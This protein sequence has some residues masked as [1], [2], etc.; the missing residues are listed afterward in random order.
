MVR[1]CWCSIALRFNG[2]SGGQVGDTGVIR[3]DRF[4]FRVTD[5]KKENDFMLH[6]GEV[7]DGRVTV[8]EPATAEVDAKRRNAI[9]RAHTATHLLHHAL[10]NILGKHAQQ[11]GSKVEPDRLRFDFANPEAV[12]RERLR[13]IEEAVNAMILEAAPVSWSHM[14]IAEAR[15]QGAMALFGEKYPDIV[16]V[17]RMGDYSRELCGGTHLDSV[18]QVG[19]FKIIGE[20]SVASGIRRITAL[21]G[22]GASAHV[23]QEE[24]LLLGLAA[25]LRVP[26]TQIADRV[27]GLV[28]EVKTLKKQ[29]TQRKTEVA[30]KT[31]A[32]DL[33]RGAFEL[34]GASVIIHGLEG[35][36]LDE[37]R[38]LID[39]LRRKKE[40]GLAVLLAAAD[41]GKV[42]LVAGVTRDL[43]E[44]GLHAGNWLKE[45]A[46]V[47]GGGGGGRPDM[48]QAGGKEPEKIPAALEKA[49]GSIK[50][51]LGVAG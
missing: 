32:D 26:V 2:E 44:R 35:V 8:S 40:T 5:T 15:S 21:V 27:A 13:A 36:S 24:D 10:R 41:E 28:E 1:W 16:R 4:T 43:I 38:Q 25:S 46:P 18:A 9:R 51:K 31:S 47:V 45:V 11:A 6:L 33:L 37:M 19:F 42:Q 22:Q 23:R 20:E 29:V 48:A 12:G 39:V 34:D 3:G 50:Q 7:E 49:L 14:P 17:V 30:P